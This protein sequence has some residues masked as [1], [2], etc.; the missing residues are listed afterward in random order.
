MDDDSLKKIFKVSGDKTNKLLN[1]FKN[2]DLSMYKKASLHSEKID[3][4]LTE[5]ES[6]LFPEDFEFESANLPIIGTQK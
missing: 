6:L 5:M 3:V 1:I 4:D 2:Y